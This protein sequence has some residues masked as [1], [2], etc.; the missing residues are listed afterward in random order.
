MED[1]A[2]EKSAKRFHGTKGPF[3]AP[4]L[5]QKK[6]YRCKT[7]QETIR[8]RKEVTSPSKLASYARHVR[9]VLPIRDKYGK[10]LGTTS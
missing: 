7:F 5:P 9:E 2:F 1:V 6:E 8:G 4:N 3:P 10:G